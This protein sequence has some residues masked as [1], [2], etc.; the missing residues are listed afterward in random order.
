MGYIVEVGRK[1]EIYLSVATDSV[2]T[3]V[4]SHASAVSLLE[5]GGDGVWKTERPGNDNNNLKQTA[6]DRLSDKANSW[7][8]K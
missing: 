4:E 6:G 3:H 5:S 8:Q 7:R 1:R 2:T